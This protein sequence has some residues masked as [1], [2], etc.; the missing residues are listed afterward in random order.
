MTY[1]GHGPSLENVEPVCVT[2]VVGSTPSGLFVLVTDVTG[3]KLVVKVPTEI[4]GALSALGHYG[5]V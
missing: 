5:E 2:E 4:V 3:S 1:L